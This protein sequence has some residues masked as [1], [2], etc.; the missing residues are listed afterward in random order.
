[1]S[2][3]VIV[4]GK[5]VKAR[6][7]RRHK[8]VLT[9]DVANSVDEHMN[10][11]ENTGTGVEQTAS[12]LISKEPNPLLRQRS[13]SAISS[14]SGQLRE[15][16]APLHGQIERLLQLPGAIRTCADYKDWLGRFLGLYDPLE[17]SLATFSG[18][19]SLGLSILSRNHTRCLVDDLVALGTDPR[20]LPRASSAL[21]PDLPTFAHALGSLYVIEG[22]TL[23]GRLI[24]RDLEPRIGT[25][26]TGATG[27]FGGR[28]EAVGPMWQSFRVALEEF[29]ARQPR[30]CADV[31]VGAERTFRAML[32]WFARF[33][34]VKGG[35]P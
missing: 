18:W 22:A 6:I 17:C 4:E 3:A 21:L 24:L 15:R 2:S 7:P 29:G 19:D 8:F 5:R 23:G 33:S 11:L 9:P 35:Q 12:Q 10:S 14:L 27:F 13:V 26:I 25:L 34:V 1:M 31:V 32:V 30:L 20:E 28:G 16:T